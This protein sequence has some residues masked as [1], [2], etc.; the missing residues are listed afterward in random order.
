M[1]DGDDG[2]R[3]A[4]AVDRNGVG[5]RRTAA[6]VVLSWV[7]AVGVDLFLNAGVFAGTFFEP[8]PFLLP[9]EVLFVRIPLGYLS[10]LIQAA[11]VAWLLVRLEVTGWRAGGRLGASVGVVVHGAGTLA[12]ASVSTAS[13]SLLVAWFVG[14]TLQVTGAGVVVGHG[15]TGAR[16]RRIALVVCAVA[17]ALA[18]ATFAMQSLGVVPTPTST[19]AGVLDA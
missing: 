8:S 19:L 14:Q 15:L 2:V 17:L 5:T 12:L 11:F 4:T 10:F 7:L 18:V 9:P 6:L 16:L 3:S 1:D 13:A